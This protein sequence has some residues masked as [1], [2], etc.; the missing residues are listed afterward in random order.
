MASR[1][2]E[3][4]TTY[5]PC[6]GI[7]ISGAGP[8]RPKQGPSEDA[9]F[10]I[11]LRSIPASG[12]GVGQDPQLLILLSVQVQQS[13]PRGTWVGN[14]AS[15]ACGSACWCRWL[16]REQR[17]SCA[18]R[19]LHHPQAVRRILREAERRSALS[20]S[21]RAALRSSFCGY[22][23]G[24]NIATQGVHQHTACDS[25]P[26]SWE[27][28]REFRRLLVAQVTQR[29]ECH[30]SADAPQ[31]VGNCQDLPCLRNRPKKGRS[32]ACHCCGHDQT[33]LPHRLV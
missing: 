2:R 28:P 30:P 11:V 4:A 10:I 26:Y 31:P 18:P 21:S 15:A 27:S 8:R 14:N 12:D 1:S 23:R 29:G 33:S 6:Q 16:S 25:D 32:P 13:P 19:R 3:P 9:H 5:C 17:S 7:S 20:E 22:P 24:Q